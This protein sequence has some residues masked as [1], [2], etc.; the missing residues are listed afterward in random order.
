MRWRPRLD[1]L[2]ARLIAAAAVWT[3]LGLIVGGFVLSGI[4]SASLQSEFDGRLKF[5]LDGM[6][7]AAEPDPSGGV[8][9]Q[10]RFTDPRFER[11]Y[12]GWYWQ[13][14]PDVHPARG[15]AA[16]DD[17]QISRS[18]WDKTIRQTDRSVRSS[19]TWGHGTGPE[20]QHVRFVSRH[21]AFPVAATAA[22]GDSRGY[23]FLVAGDMSEVDSE[24]ARFDRMLSWSFALLAL[25]L[26][27]AIFLQV[28][29][30]LQPLRK[31]SLRL[32]DIRDGKARRL[33]GKYPAEIAPL[34]AELNSLIGHSEEVVGRARTHV[35]NLAHALKTPLSV[36]SGEASAAPGPLGEAVERQ[37]EAMRRHVD[38]YLTRARAAGALDVI[39]TRTPVKPVL[40]D[41]ARVLRRIH[42]EKDVIINI[43]CP[44]ALVFRGE[45]QDLDE[46][47]G[48]LMDNACKWARTRIAVV[49]RAEEAGR[50]L[51]TVGDDGPGLTAEERARVG[52]RGERLDES[53]P[54][55]GLGL[56][57]VRDI[58]KL[59]GGSLDLGASALGGLEARLTLPAIG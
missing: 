14:I 2:A 47:A 38:H 12:S 49:A 33:A 30:G 36:L 10:G 5:D 54:G 7:A 35:S 34:A 11:I 50:L 3:M 20:N 8:S 42:A 40:D 57:I 45:K 53:V 1:S 25:G 21:V 46:L 28:R 15:T 55:S 59:Y 23:T 31:L 9:L 24:V 44:L 6:I 19:L 43:D 32:A 13:I 41:L 27:G 16:A 37:V 52:A 58:A 17:V 18:L 4:F 22:P 39:G 51:L 56:A 48:N 29:I 26:I